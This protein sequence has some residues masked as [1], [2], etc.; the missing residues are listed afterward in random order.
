MI[1]TLA[2]MMFVGMRSPLLIWTEKYLAP[3][4]STEKMILFV[5]NPNERVGVGV[6]DV[7][8]PSN[9]KR[10]DARQTCEGVGV[11]SFRNTSTSADEPGSI[12]K[13]TV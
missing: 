1:F 5:P 9:D 11:V 4:E 7:V 3:I 2:L 6:C 13:M 12:S 8:T 10:M